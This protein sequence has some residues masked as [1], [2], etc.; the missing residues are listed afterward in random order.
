MS[1]IHPR[2]V[3][4]QLPAHRQV[5]AAFFLYAFAFGGFFPRL[6]ELQ[7]SMG[8][9][10]GQLG[11]GLIGAACGTL[12]SLSFAGRWIE[13]IGHRRTLLVLLPLLPV[14]YA[15]ATHARGPAALFL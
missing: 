2:S 11:L 14:V 10:E 5:F 6:A 9:T 4:L 15:L 12:F 7:R 13:R 8:V 1:V 3:G